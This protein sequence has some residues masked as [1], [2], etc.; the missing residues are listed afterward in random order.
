MD[1]EKVAILHSSL[2]NNMHFL[3]YRFGVCHYFPYNE[4]HSSFIIYNEVKQP[5]ET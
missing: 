2:Y 1:K 4:C 3:G 5:Y